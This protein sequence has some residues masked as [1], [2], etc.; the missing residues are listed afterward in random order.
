[1]QAGNN[2]EDVIRSDAHEVGQEKRVSADALD[3]APASR[4][5]SQSDHHLETRATFDS[6]SRT[7]ICDISQ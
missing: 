2:V 4:A 3:R 7:I 1:M 6:V 5:Q